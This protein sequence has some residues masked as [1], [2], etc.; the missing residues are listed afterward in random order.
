M[1]R[2]ALDALALELVNHRHEWSIELRQD[3]ERAIEIAQR[4]EKHHGMAGRPVLNLV[5]VGKTEV[6]DA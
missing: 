6:T 3:Y 2:R 1:I 4:Y 5:V